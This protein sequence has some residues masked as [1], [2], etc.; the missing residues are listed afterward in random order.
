MGVTAPCFL[1]LI[2]IVWRNFVVILSNSCP[3]YA[4]L[5]LGDHLNR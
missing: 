1:L 2:S 4:S 3:A 5:D